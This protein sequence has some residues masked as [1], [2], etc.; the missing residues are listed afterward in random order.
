MT[1]IPVQIG[2]PSVKPNGISGSPSS[3]FWI[4]VPIAKA[5]QS[6]VRIVQATRKSKGNL[7]CRITVFGDIAITVIADRFNDIATAVGNH[8]WTAQVIALNKIALTTLGKATGGMP[9]G[10]LKALFDLS[11]A[12]IDCQQ[13]GQVLPQVL[14][15][16]LTI[17]Q[18]GHSVA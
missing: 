2:I 14:F 9:Q 16:Y 10:I 18:L 8:P 7:K 1:N 12:V 15:H 13:R 6:S 4:V 17:N 11:A 5:N 3:G